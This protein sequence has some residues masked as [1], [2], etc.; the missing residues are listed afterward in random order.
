MPVFNKLNIMNKEI[1]TII[2]SGYVGT[3]FGA[4][5]AAAGI[6]TY[7][8][9]LDEKKIE[10]LKSGKSYF[11]EPYLDEFIKKGMDSGLLY[12]TM[13]Y[14]E[15]FKDSTI[16]FSCVGTPD[17]PDGNVNLAY[18]YAAAEEATRNAKNDIIYVQKST[19]P[20]GT[21]RSV[22]EKMKEIR[23][24]ID[25]TYISNPEF[26]REGSAMFDTMYPDRVVVGGDDKSSVER[27]IKIYEHVLEFSKT[28]NS[29]EDKYGS[30][31]S[32]TSITE[33]KYFETTIPSAELIKVS[34]NAFL[35]LKISFANS[36]AT[37][38]DKSGANVAE[39]MDGI[40][41][42]KRIGRSFL[43]PGL[44]YGG[45]CF[46]KDV[47]GLQ[48]SFENAGL[49]NPILDAA[50]EVNS[51]MPAYV[52]N[53][54]KQELGE[55]SDK[56]I[57]LLGLAFKS[58]TSDCRKSP[59]I[60][61][62]N[63]LVENGANISAFDPQVDREE[64]KHEKLSE[65]VNILAEVDEIPSVDIVIIATEWPEFK[66]LNWKNF[67]DNV[68][69]GVIIDAR[70]ILNKKEIEKLGYKYLGVGI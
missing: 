51:N 6:K 10:T 56:N 69:S 41:A 23:S 61:L 33:T 44:G 49:T 20:V 2:G 58:G 42:D 60:K 9:D 39:V 66:S 34:A 18:I 38:S 21:G 31:F 19:V 36:I 54:V 63:L 47:A 8:V 62:A 40:G 45:G 67:K 32:T 7:L 16:A 27:I 48:K 13:S 24:D 29:L 15:A 59:A 25:I 50:V 14:E 37:L 68:S 46:P 12:P 53:K 5:L 22:L 43:Y 65:S 17:L 30:A 70:N 57:L 11:F 3:T 52:L 4:L 26:L 64:L 35:A 1:I 28:F 55:L